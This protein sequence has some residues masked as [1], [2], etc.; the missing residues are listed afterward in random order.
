MC[1]ELR[2]VCRSIQA[3]HEDLD[4]DG[5]DALSAAFQMPGILC[6]APEYADGIMQIS[7]SLMWGKAIVE[8]TAADLAASSSW[9]Q[10][11]ESC[12]QSRVLALVADQPL[13]HWAWRNQDRVLLNGLQPLPALTPRESM[14]LS[15][16]EPLRQSPRWLTS[17]ASSWGCPRQPRPAPR[18]GCGAAERLLCEALDEAPA[19][20]SLS[21]RLLHVLQLALKGEEERV[22]ES[23]GAAKA[24]LQ[25]LKLPDLGT[26][27]AEAAEASEEEALR[28]ALR[29]FQQACGFTACELLA[30]RTEAWPEATA[31][32]EA[33]TSA[34]GRVAARLA[35]FAPPP[36]DESGESGGSPKV[37]ALGSSGVPVLT[38]LLSCL[39]LLLPVVLHLTN[40]LPKSGKKA[41]A[42]DPLHD[43][44]LALRDL[45]Q[46]L[47]RFL[48]E[49]PESAEASA[50]AAEVPGAGAVAEALKCVE[51]FHAQRREL[52]VAMLDAHQK[53]IKSLGELMAQRVQL[54]KSKAFKP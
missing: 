27:A 5:G 49:V 13:E 9:E 1:P 3:F 33:L 40:A 2:E 53:Q 7:R 43:T 50:A 16:E 52:E 26:C 44:R 51:D 19:Q 45:L 24:A 42:G 8:E 29:R 35:A 32:L 48:T 10:L 18:E 17:F 23:L 31:S 4:K 54:L 38:T 15:P 34:F 37:W 20:L 6:R 21:A 39:N 30:K 12:R 11:A 28:K 46:A 36:R 47:Q 22:T 14:G 41:K 25:A